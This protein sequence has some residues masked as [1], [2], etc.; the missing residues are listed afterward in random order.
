[1]TDYDYVIPEH[2]I[3]VIKRVCLHRLYL[4][5]LEC[6]ENTPNLQEARKGITELH[7]ID[8]ALKHVKMPI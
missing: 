7:L 4:R 3:A 5:D 8:Q 1:M 2:V 6:F